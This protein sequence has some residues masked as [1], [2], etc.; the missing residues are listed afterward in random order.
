M[1]DYSLSETSSENSNS[2]DYV[3]SIFGKDITTLNYSTNNDKLFNAISNGYYNIT[4]NNKEISLI[5]ENWKELT[6]DFYLRMSYFNG[7]STKITLVSQTIERNLTFEDIVFDDIS[8]VFYFSGI[9]NFKNCIFK[10]NKYSALFIKA[11]NIILNFENC[12]VIDTRPDIAEWIANTDYVQYWRYN[13]INVYGNNCIINVKNSE[14]KNIMAEHFIYLPENKTGCKFYI[15]NNIFDTIEGNGIA[16]ESSVSGYIKNNIFKNIGELR[17]YYGN[18]DRTDGVGTNAIF[19]KNAIYCDMDIS[20]NYIYNVNENG[21]EGSYRSVCRNKIENTGYRN[22][23]GYTNP[24]TEGI[25][26]GSR[27]VKDNIII[28][29][30]AEGIVVESWNNAE[31]IIENNT[32]ISD[33]NKQTQA[34]KTVCDSNNNSNIS[35]YNN[36]IKGYA[37]AYNFINNNTVNLNNIKLYD[38]IMVG[39]SVINITSSTWYPQ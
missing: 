24:S 33:E 16:F 27:L 17:G 15:E 9:I 12:K 11:D 31:C 19:T 25:W 4:T 10:N 20:D 29:P 36:I 14:F 23:L 8:F 13:S 34:I 2:S 5:S 6:N 21:I 39:S 1:N 18:G 28:N 3:L 26:G 37:L 32:I 30:L 7:S 35:I 38:P 22:S